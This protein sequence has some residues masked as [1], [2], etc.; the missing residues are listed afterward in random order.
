MSLSLSDRFTFINLTTK[1]EKKDRWSKTDRNGHRQGERSA[2]F[3]FSAL[4]Q[5]T[6]LF[7]PGIITTVMWEYSS[8]NNELCG[9]RL[10]SLQKY[11]LVTFTSVGESRLT[12]KAPNK[13][14]SLSLPWL[15]LSI[16][17]GYLNFNLVYNIYI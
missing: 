16:I 13:H 6:D 10:L 1:R 9:F 8:I 11:K 14:P 4:F 17:A 5:H 3:N 12:P 15:S 7:P 2:P